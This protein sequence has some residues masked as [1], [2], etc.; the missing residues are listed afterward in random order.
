MSDEPLNQVLEALME[1]KVSL[2]DVANTSANGQLDE[3][4]QLVEQCVE[5][6]N[7]DDEIVDTILSCIG[8]LL[9]ALP[10]IAALIKLIAD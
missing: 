2:H 1:L 7:A 9:E 3:I 4:I 5:N 8:K 6:G 10:S